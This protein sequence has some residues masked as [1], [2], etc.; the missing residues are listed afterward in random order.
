MP[1]PRWGQVRE[2]CRKLGYRETRTDHYHYVKVLPD[3]LVSR[4][5][6]SFGSEGVVVPAQMW[7][8]VWKHQLKLATEEEFWRGLSGEAVHYVAQPE[9]E[10]AQPLPAYL[11]R[12]LRDVRHLPDE[13][14]SGITRD[15]AQDLLNRY[16]CA[17]LR[18]ER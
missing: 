1:R 15:E 12:F 2:F 11:L 7:L 14:I 3:R 18:E 8:M 13:E 16:Y 5:M 6:V 10:P 4:T 17:N 9:P